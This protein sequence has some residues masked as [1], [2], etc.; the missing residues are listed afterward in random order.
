MCM[1][2]VAFLLTRHADDLDSANLLS[3]GAGGWVDLWN[4]HG[5]GL[6]GEFNVWD[7]TRMK[8]DHELWHLE[9]VT[10]LKVNSQ[11]TVL[12]T[13]NSMGYLQ[14]GKLCHGS[15]LEYVCP[16]IDIRWYSPCIRASHMDTTVNSASFNCDS[17]Y[18]TVSAQ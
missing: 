7:T 1:L 17:L 4:T 8:L 6:L 10:S 12:I 13:G 16:R 14:V 5:G 2:Q 9:S 3:C 18:V 15:P 11:D